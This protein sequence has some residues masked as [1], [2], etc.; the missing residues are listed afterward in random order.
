MPYLPSIS[1]YKPFYIQTESDTRALDTAVQWG[2]VAKTNPFPLLPSP[3][4]PFKNEW[5]DENGDDEYVAS[6]HYES[7]EF[8]V[9]F[10]IKTY[11]VTGKTAE[12]VLREQVDAFFSKIRQGP[13]MVYDSYTGVGRKDV[14]YAGYKE[15]T[16]KRS[17]DWARAIFTITFKANDPITR[18]GIANGK[19]VEV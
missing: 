17:G 19:L 1:N 14:R 10:Y 15:D 13:F 5:F 9:S 6:M 18:V 16:F 7:I 8:E 3:K 11:A 2:L 4:E 12:Q